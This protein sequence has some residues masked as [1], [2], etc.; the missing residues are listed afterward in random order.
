MC[1]FSG[2]ACLSCTLGAS[3]LLYNVVNRAISDV[4]VNICQYVVFIIKLNIVILTCTSDRFPPI[5]PTLAMLPTSRIELIGRVRPVLPVG[6][7]P[8]VRY[9]QQA[10]ITLDLG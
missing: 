10:V 2:G 7:W 1:K 8:G 9:R 6:G 5:L 4:Q 3:L